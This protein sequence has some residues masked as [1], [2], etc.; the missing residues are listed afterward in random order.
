MFAVYSK[1]CPVVPTQRILSLFKARNESF[2]CN[3]VCTMIARRLLFE[4]LNN[5]L[6]RFAERS[7]LHNLMTYLYETFVHERGLLLGLCHGL[8][9]FWGS[10][11]SC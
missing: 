8:S 10:I 7:R 11:N 2:N 4:K 5:N 1:Q 6:Q 3:I 9:H